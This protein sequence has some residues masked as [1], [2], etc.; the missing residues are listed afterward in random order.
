MRRRR[1][2]C[3]FGFLHSAD[4]FLRVL[5]LQHSARKACQQPVIIIM[6][7][8][9]MPDKR[10]R[11]PMH[12][13]LY[14]FADQSAKITPLEHV[15]ALFVYNLTLLIHDVVVREDILS[16]IEVLI[17]YAFLRWIRYYWKEFSRRSAY[18][19]PAPACPPC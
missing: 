12:D 16:P 7:L 13:R 14:P 4:L 17:L 2:L 5:Q 9:V 10:H 1:R 6:L 3:K 8:A 18:P 15:A 11:D 19:R